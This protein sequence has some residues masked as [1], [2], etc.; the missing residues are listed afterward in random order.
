M[1]LPRTDAKQV[2]EFDRKLGTAA[3]EICPMYG[4]DPQ[5]CIDDAAKSTVFGKFAL[6]NNYFNMDG[7]G[8]LGHNFL[9]RSVPTGRVVNGGYAVSMR[10]VAKFSS[11]TAAVTEYCTRRQRGWDYVR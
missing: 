9:M 11:P 10:K 6:H 3:R 7:D 1:T 2:A 8:D 4:I 5:E